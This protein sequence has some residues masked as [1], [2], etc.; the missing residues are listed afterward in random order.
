VGEM[1][2]DRHGSPEQWEARG[3]KKLTYGT[4]LG[5]PRR[6]AQGVRKDSCHPTGGEK[7]CS[8]RNAARGILRGPASSGSNNR[9]NNRL[10]VGLV[11]EGGGGGVWGGVGKGGG[12]CGVGGGVGLG[13]GFGGGGLGGVGGGGG[14]WWL[15]G[16]LGLW[17][18]E[19]EA[20]KIVKKQQ[21]GRRIRGGIALV[22]LLT[23]RPG[24]AARQVCS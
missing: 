24:H 7:G 3:R 12:G 19:G 10:R 22:N 11:L 23:G 16:V 1:V 13:G 18:E 14:G 4:T 17:Q 8:T 15:G 21:S 2:S 5:N 9:L 20:W 6:P